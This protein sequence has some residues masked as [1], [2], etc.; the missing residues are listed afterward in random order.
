MKAARSHD[1]TV[2]DML[3]ADPEFAAIYLAAALEEAEL[4]GG[5][6]ALLAALLKLPQHWS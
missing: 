5:Q 4:P 3:R 1:A 2:V 6:S